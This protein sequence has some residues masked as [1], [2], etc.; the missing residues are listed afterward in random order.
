VGRRLI[1]RYHAR[2]GFDRLSDVD[3]V[4]LL[5]MLL[6]VSSLALEPV[7]NAYSRLQEHEADRFALELTRTNRSA[8]LAFVKLQRENLSNPRP[9]PFYKTWRSTHPSSGER[10]DFCNAYHPWT[11]GRPLRYAAWIRP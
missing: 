8:A 7:A 6:Q 1:T 4:P 9:G 10:I 3:S 2:F 11:E 5:M